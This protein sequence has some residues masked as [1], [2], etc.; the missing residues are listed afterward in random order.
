MPNRLSS[1]EIERYRRDGC[2]FPI[3]ALSPEEAGTCRERLEAAEA[4]HGE[5]MRAYLRDDPHYVFPFLYDLVFHAAVLDAVEDV[6]GP[7][8]LAWSSGFFTKDAGDRRIVSWHQDARYWG[9]EPPIGVSAW[10]AFSPS[11]PESGCMRFVPGTHRGDVVAHVDTFA[12]DNMLTRGQAIADPVDERRA[13]DVTLRPGEM[14][15]HHMKVFHGSRVNLSRDRRIG[16]AVTYIPTRVRQAVG[17]ADEA[18]LVRG[19]DAYGHFE[20]APRPKADLAPEAVAYHAA[21]LDRHSRVLY[22]GQQRAHA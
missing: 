8:I 3:E 16:F 13:V 17:Q 6:I 4:R 7:D 18:I 1:S 14:S 2:C 19:T 11:T 9:L 22:R 5:S 15:L 20:P 10:I 12:D 21:T